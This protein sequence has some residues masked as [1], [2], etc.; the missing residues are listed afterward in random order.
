M[1][2]SCFYVL[3]SFFLVRKFV[4]HMKKS[5]SRILFCLLQLISHLWNYWK[6]CFRIQRSRRRLRKGLSYYLYFLC[7]W[8][9]RNAHSLM[10]EFI[11]AASNEK[12]CCRGQYSCQV[13]SFMILHSRDGVYRCGDC[14]YCWWHLWPCKS[15]LTRLY[16]CIL[17]RSLDRNT[18]IQIIHL[19]A[20]VPRMNTKVRE[21]RE[22]WLVV[23]K[24]ITAY[25]SLDLS[26]SQC[27]WLIH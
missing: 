25:M 26:Q 3:P 8:V 12:D 4:K 20:S 1:H 22:I 16:Y 14:L 13:Q 18:P 7:C 6:Q 2:F 19:Q 23:E 5:N 24:C 11:W 15:W 27:G 10:R 17:I 21:I 9:Y